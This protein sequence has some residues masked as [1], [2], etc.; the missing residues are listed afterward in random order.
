MNTGI[1][2]LFHDVF[3][4]TYIHNKRLHVGFDLMHV[5]VMICYINVSLHVRRRPDGKLATV[6]SLVRH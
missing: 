1:L 5:E 6:T 2:L 3:Y 4:N